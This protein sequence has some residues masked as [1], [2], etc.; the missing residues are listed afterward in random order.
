MS[1]IIILNSKKI[2][3]TT[4][5]ALCDAE[6]QHESHNETLEWDSN[7][8][9][10]KL[11]ERFIFLGTMFPRLAHCTDALLEADSVLIYYRRCLLQL[12]ATGMLEF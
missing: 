12:T 6:E 11:L 10:L 5:S 8:S 3:N 9:H 7:L 1:S 4:V 2:L